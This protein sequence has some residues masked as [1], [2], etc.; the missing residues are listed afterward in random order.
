M[1]KDILNSHIPGVA[2]IQD[3]AEKGDNH[4]AIDAET[5]E[6]SDATD[7]N[8]QNEGQEHTRS[9]MALLFVLGFFAI[10]FLCFLYAIMVDASLK[11]LKE[12]LTAVVG[13]LSGILGFIVGYYYKSAQ[14]K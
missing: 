6:V 8:P 1:E 10:L 11:E 14:E 4:D 12:T 2:D 9:K 7:G 3:K 5:K 13:A